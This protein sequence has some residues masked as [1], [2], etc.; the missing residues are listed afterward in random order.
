VRRVRALVAGACAGLCAAA[1]AR[2]AGSLSVAAAANL[3]YVLA[4]LDEEF[5]RAYPGT[6]VTT[7]VGASGGLVAQI[8][9]GAPYD[10][11][12]SADPD[13]ARA[14]VASGDAD[15]GSLAPFAS[16]RLV[17]WTARPGLEVSDIAAAVRNPAV[18]ALAIANVASAPYG[19]AARQALERL[20]LWADAQPKLVTAENIS[21]AAQFVDT[22]SADAGF[23]A[24][25]AVLSPRL[26]GRGRW[27]E[28]P[29]GLY[30]PLTQVAVVTARGRANPN[31][32]LYVAFLRGG[33]A[34]AVLEGFG[35]AG[36]APAAGA[37][38]APQRP[39]R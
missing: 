35:Y 30:E 15:P 4:A 37:R 6:A 25:S 28:V 17:L 2:G 16:G 27:A 39:A 18:R 5:G 10:V 14:L 29:A 38:D 8:R 13:F 33:A 1:A 26:R 20:G 23:V 11:F 19:R 24:L 12:L 22:G 36:P 21:Q 32:A 7:A 31:A 34:R 9:N 3:S